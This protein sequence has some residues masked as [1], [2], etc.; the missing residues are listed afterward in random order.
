[1]KVQEKKKYILKVTIVISIVLLVICTIAGCV[2]AY[3]TC[4]VYAD[5][6][7]DIGGNIEKLD[8]EETVNLWEK[9]IKVNADPKGEDIFVRVK[10]YVPSQVKF[11]YS[12]NGWELKE[13]GYYYY[14]P[15]VKAGTS[16]EVFNI[17]IDPKELTDEFDVIIVQE[18]TDAIYD[19]N[20][21]AYADWESVYILDD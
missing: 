19:E 12:G 15:L 4:Y 16:T 1:M 18:A 6:T 2:Y 11:S 14:N 9:Q 7:L 5:G 10:I 20:K 21:K 3:F 8:L 17:N 13:D